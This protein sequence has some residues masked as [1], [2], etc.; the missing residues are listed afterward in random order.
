MAIIG[1]GNVSIDVARMLLT[2]PKLLQVLH[3]TT[4]SIPF[5]YLHVLYGATVLY[6]QPVFHH[7]ATTFRSP[8]VDRRDGSLAGAA[9]AT[10]SP[11]AR[12]P[13]DRAARA[14]ARR[15]HD[16]RAARAAAS[17]G[18]RAALRALRPL[19]RAGALGL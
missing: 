18:R 4:P 2:A 19:R 14:A 9:R 5:S 13:R 11:S 3:C 17:A 1:H 6:K 15:V 16:R 7:S 8:L 12:R 10:A